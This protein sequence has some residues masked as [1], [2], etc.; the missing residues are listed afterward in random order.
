MG[1]L[2]LIAEEG[3]GVAE[4]ILELLLVGGAIFGLLYLVFWKD[5]KSEPKRKE[6]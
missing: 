3:F 5:R 2:G 4:F 6:K 1:F